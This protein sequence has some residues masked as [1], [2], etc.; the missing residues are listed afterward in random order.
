MQRI[1]LSEIHQHL[2]GLAKEFDRVCTKNSIPYYMAYGTMLGAV[3]HK[4]FIPWDD[5]MDFVV[6]IEYYQQ[7]LKCLDRDL[8]EP[9][10]CCT[11]KNCKAVIHCYAKIEDTSTILDD[12]AFNVPLEDKTG[13]NIDIFPLNRFDCIDTRIK[14]V[15]RYIYLLGGAFSNSKLHKSTF[16]KLRKKI[17]RLLLGGKP[18]YLQNK[19][20]RISYSLTKGEKLGSIFDNPNIDPIPEYW[21]GKGKRYIF[22]NLT[23]V[24]PE[25]YDKYLTHMYGDYMTPPP[26]NKRV[27]HAE[28]VYI[29][30]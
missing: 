28:N 12:A 21:Y 30:N 8:T 23:L 2:L 4:G 9:Y 1:G 5:D 16:N 3:R 26:N 14:R 22:E 29:R 10:R 20:E 7:L 24:G 27:A 6:P 11:H 19:I 13:I 15:H 17:L 18:I 25:D